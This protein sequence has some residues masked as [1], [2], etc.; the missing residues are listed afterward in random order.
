MLLLM[1]VAVLVT[2]PFVR[3]VDMFYTSDANVYYHAA[4]MIG[5]E[6]RFGTQQRQKG[7]ILL[8][9]T[10]YPAMPIGYSLLAYPA[11]KLGEVASLP[12]QRIELGGS[13]QPTGGG[14]FPAAF[15]MR[16]N[17]T[18]TVQAEPGRAKNHLSLFMVVRSVVGEKRLVATAGDR[19]V[20]NATHG[21][22]W[23]KIA[24][25]T[26]LED[27]RNV[28]RF[29][30]PGSCERVE[31][32]FRFTTD[33]RCATFAVRDVF[34][35]FG[36]AT[37]PDLR[38][39]SDILLLRNGSTVGPRVVNWNAYGI[40]RRLAF[41][42]WGYNRSAPLVLRVYNG[43]V[44]RPNG[45]ANRTLLAEH[46]FDI[47]ASGRDIIT[48]RLP[49]P[50]GNATVVF[51][52]PVSCADYGDR[53]LVAGVRKMEL[54]R[55]ETFRTRDLTFRGGWY[56]P[57]TTGLR[58]MDGDAAIEVRRPA[59]T[60]RVRVRSFDHARTLRITRDGTTMNET[61]GT[62]WRT[63]R[64]PAGDGRIRFETDGCDIPGTNPGSQDKRCLA[65][66]FHDIE[67][68]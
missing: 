15:W 18:V 7:W 24:V 30:T 10:Y 41:R 62:A 11:G 31:T 36:P 64:I 65:V 51:D 13:F 48:P 63:L 29:S 26:P 21:E 66:A 58:W 45:T 39:D 9:G 35:A 67:L 23:T 38:S 61:V 42:A 3:T 50:P 53:C 27:G 4:D 1:L 55:E 14:I 49:L 34:A 16:G 22:D 19:V 25:H 6:A 2:L 17:G 57:E 33:R 52:T 37:E 60:M 12:Q 28:I 5:D 68:D 8:N 43:T 32:V 20:H 46:R 56:R 54:L 47:P 59:E 40:D 44:A